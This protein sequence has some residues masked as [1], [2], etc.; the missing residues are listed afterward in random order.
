M[1]YVDTFERKEIKH[2]LDSQ[3]Y[4]AMLQAIAPHMCLDTYGKS[5]ITSLYYD[6]PTWDLIERSLD[7]PLYKEKLRVRTYGNQSTA[8]TPAFVELKKKYQGIVYKRRICMT[9]QGAKAYLDDMPYTQACKQYPHSDSTQQDA[10]LD[11]KSMQIAREID[12]FKDFYQPLTP[13]IAIRVERSAWAPIEG[14]HEDFATDNLRITFD[15]DMYYL[16]TRTHKHNYRQLVDSGMCIMEVKAL[17]AIPRWLVDALNIA[18]IKPSSF[19]KYGRAY[20][21]ERSKQAC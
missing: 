13:S 10:S 8:K 20:T 21:L 4:L 6:T 12:H 9:Q 5:T 14:T 18:N 19:S 1:A 15:E 17:G 3:Q 2:V 16:N 11:A 7:K